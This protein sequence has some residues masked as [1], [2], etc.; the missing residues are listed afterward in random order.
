MLSIKSECL[1]HF[2]VGGE[3]HLRDLVSQYVAHYN[4]ARPHQGVGNRPLGSAES[5][6]P[7]PLAAR[8]IVCDARLGGLLRHYRRAS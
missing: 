6:E 2:I 3:T 5:P 7:S 1:D 8:D 4:T